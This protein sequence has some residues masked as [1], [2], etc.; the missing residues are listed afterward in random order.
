MR[1]AHRV[2]C[3]NKRD[4]DLN[5]DR[6]KDSMRQVSMQV[7]L[8]R[9]IT[10]RNQITK[11]RKNI[12]PRATAYQGIKQQVPAIRKA[13]QNADTRGPWQRRREGGR[14]GPKLPFTHLRDD[15]HQDHLF[16][17]FTPYICRKKICCAGRTC[18]VQIQSRNQSKNTQ[19]VRLPRSNMIP[20]PCKSCTPRMHL[21]CMTYIILI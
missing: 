8:K 16:R 13:C 10:L 14:E 19:I 1:Q 5:C 20:R 15:D 21:P 18:A 9:L 3:D 4:S 12:L 6:S 7:Y 17:P 2:S 11:D